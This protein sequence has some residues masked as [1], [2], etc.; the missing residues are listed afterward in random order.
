MKLGGIKV[1][2]FVAGIETE[3]A[4]PPGREAGV[5]SPVT[6]KREPP[7]KNNRKA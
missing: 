5:Y 3:L 7:K 2:E 1:K 6:P 4:R